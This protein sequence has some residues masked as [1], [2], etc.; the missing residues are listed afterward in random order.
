MKVHIAASYSGG[1]CNNVNL[2]VSRHLMPIER[3]PVVRLAVVVD[4]ERDASGL[5]SVH[6][7]GVEW[8]PNTKDHLLI[9]NI[10]IRGHRSPVQGNHNFHI[11]RL[12]CDHILM[13]GPR[14]IK[15]G[16]QRSLKAHP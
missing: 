2:P 9:P 6:D 12:V 8:Q 5:L 13:P 16:K 15:N 3:P 10:L 7:P 11:I 1:T 14:R 4:V